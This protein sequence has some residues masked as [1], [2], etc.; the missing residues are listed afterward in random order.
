MAKKL[1]QILV[2]DVETTC[3]EGQPQPGQ[4]TVLIHWR[5]QATLALTPSPRIT[6]S[7][8]ATQQPELPVVVGS[9]GQVDPAQACPPHHPLDVGPIIQGQTVAAEAF[10]GQGFLGGKAGDQHFRSR[11]APAPVRR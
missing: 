1:D 6:T 7:L 11:Q 4:Q 8:L 5:P 9:P 10:S 2:I 3:W